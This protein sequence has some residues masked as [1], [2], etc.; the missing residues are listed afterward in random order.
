MMQLCNAISKL[1]IVDALLHQLISK[2][3]RRR[4]WSQT[5][6]PHVSSVLVVQFPH[7]RISTRRIKAW[8]VQGTLSFGFISFDDETVVYTICRNEKRPTDG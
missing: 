3:W 4:Q 7:P 1:D 6:S 5:S 8:Q 2:I